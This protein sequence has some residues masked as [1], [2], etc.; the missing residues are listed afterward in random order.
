M[1]RRLLLPAKS[2]AAK[3]A[4][5]MIVDDI[6]RTMPEPHTDTVFDD[7]GFA[8]CL[9]PLSPRNVDMAFEGVVS[10][11]TADTAIGA[12]DDDAAVVESRPDS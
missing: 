10:T 5:G 2:A 8:V 3:V 12:E 11:C 4:V 1:P 9:L 6:W 7:V